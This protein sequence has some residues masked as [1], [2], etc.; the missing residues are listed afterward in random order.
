MYLIKKVL[1]QLG[2]YTYL[3][4]WGIAILRLIGR[5][6]ISLNIQGIVFNTDYSTI[7]SERAFNGSEELRN[8]IQGFIKHSKGRTGFLDVGAY[9]GVFSIIFTKI[10]EDSNVYAFEPSSKAFK[11]LEM[12]AT[13]ND[14]DRIHLSRLA[15]GDSDSEINMEFEGNHIVYAKNGQK[16]KQNTIDHLVYNEGILFDTIKIDVEGYEYHVLK[17]AKRFLNESDPLIFLEIHPERLDK[18]GVS[19]KDV[20]TFLSSLDYQMIDASNIDRQKEYRVI[21]KK[22]E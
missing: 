19:E 3:T 15:L 9:H 6:K 18:M 5:N 13:Y 7:A 8:E 10:N 21:C 20:L 12:N 17:G 22:N 4:D 11:V 16:V 1:K 2:I 14:K